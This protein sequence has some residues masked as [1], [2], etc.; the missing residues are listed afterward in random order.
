[1]VR[2]KREKTPK[3]AKQK[4]VP[5]AKGSSWTHGRQMGGRV[6]TAALFV[7][8]ACGPVA[9]F[10]AATRPPAVVAAST[11]AQR[12]RTPDLP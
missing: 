10:A 11:Q 2:E 3:E 6:L 1:M 7:A 12:A 8:I 4:R 9:L 5:E